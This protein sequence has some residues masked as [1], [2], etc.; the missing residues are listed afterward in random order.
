MKES[1]KTTLKIKNFAVFL[2]LMVDQFKIINDTF[3][4]TAGGRIH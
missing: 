1:L 3:G 4:H 2:Y